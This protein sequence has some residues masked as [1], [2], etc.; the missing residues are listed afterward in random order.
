MDHLGEK[1]QQVFND[2]QSGSA[3]MLQ[4]LIEVLSDFFKPDRHSDN[5]LKTLQDH[6]P[7]IKDQLGHFAAV[8]HFLRKAEQQIKET[9]ND[10]EGQHQFFH[11]LEVYQKQWKNVNRRIA[12]GVLKR[13]DLSGRRIMLHSN[14][15][16]LSSLFGMMAEKHIGAQV[17]QTESR[18]EYE[19]RVLAKQVAGYGFQ[20]KLISDAAMGRFMPETDLALVGADQVHCNVFVNKTGTRALALLCREQGIPLYV[21]TD[22]RK[23]SG[24]VLSSE[25]FDEPQKPARDLWET[26]NPL[27][28]PQNI[29]F[30]TIPC[31]LVSGFITERN[32][33]LPDQ[34]CAKSGEQ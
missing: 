1:L 2:K 19:G 6:L 16:A 14:S 32:L 34:L 17:I 9:P 15:S 7:E 28:S 11:F 31:Q 13:L 23:F 21:L 18:P 12:A 27:I 20:V 5:Q 4:Q 24:F 26:D 3:A 25:D 30:E 33:L 29:W 8:G 22:S 10:V